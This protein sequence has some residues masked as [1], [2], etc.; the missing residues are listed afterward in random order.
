MRS[1]RQEI[2]LPGEPLSTPARYWSPELRHT[3]AI[4]G[5]EGSRLFDGT[6]AASLSSTLYEAASHAA[7]DES[8]SSNVSSSSA[9]LNEHTR[10]PNLALLRNDRRSRQV[11]AKLTLHKSEPKL[12]ISYTIS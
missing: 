1:V 6:D 5:E 7:G 11:D 9:S 10:T 4:L 3:N 8:D 2:F 12:F